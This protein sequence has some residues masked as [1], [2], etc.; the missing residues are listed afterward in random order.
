MTNAYNAAVDELKAYRAGI[1]I[2]QA[3]LDKY[4]RF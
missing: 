2:L 1:G 3:H 4:C